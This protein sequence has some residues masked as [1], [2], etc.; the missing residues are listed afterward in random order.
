MKNH[1]HWSW[2]ARA[3][4]KYCDYYY[5][6]GCTS[7]EVSLV[8]SVCLT[9]LLY[10]MC[11]VCPI[12]HPCR[13]PPPHSPCKCNPNWQWHGLQ[14]L[15][16]AYMISFMHAYSVYTQGLGTPTAIQHNI[17]DSKISQSQWVTQSVSQFVLVLRTGFGP[18]VIES[19][20]R[21][22]TNWATQSPRR[23]FPAHLPISPSHFWLIQWLSPAR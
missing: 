7:L 5:Y 13:P 6:L 16:H 2:P 20:I 15:S 8:L 21:C 9:S 22:S 12:L 11:V 18:H 17:F 10:M 3:P 14:N 1:A 19:W 23:T 4:Y